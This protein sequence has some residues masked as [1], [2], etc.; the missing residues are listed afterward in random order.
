MASVVAVL[1]PVLSG[2]GQQG[3]FTSLLLCYDTV[4]DFFYISCKYCLAGGSK[5]VGS[6]ALARGSMLHDDGAAT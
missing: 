4:F 6:L 2:A 5:T 3:L 1:F